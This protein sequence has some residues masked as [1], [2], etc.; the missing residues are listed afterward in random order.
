MPFGKARY[1]ANIFGFTNA[2]PCVITVDST[3][4]F[5]VG[6][7]VR[8]ANLVCTAGIQLNG[9]YTVQSLTNNTITIAEDTS[10]FGTY[11]SGGIIS[12]LESF[13]PNSSNQENY[14]MPLLPWTVFNQA[15][16]GGYVPYP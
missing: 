15:R 11:V 2:S 9:T 3:Q 4:F 1:G 13:N 5:Q 6:D 8:V 14:A 7:V 12:I 10:A 16:G